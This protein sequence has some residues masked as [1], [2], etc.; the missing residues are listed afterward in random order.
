MHTSLTWAFVKRLR[1]TVKTRLLVKGLMTAEDARLAVEN[2]LDGIVVSNHGGRAEDSGRSTIDAL[3]EILEAV[4]GKVPVMVDSGFR[5][6]TDI[7]KALAM[8]AP[9]RLRSAVPI[10][11]GS[12]PSASPAS[13]ACS[14][15]CAAS[16][17]PSWCSSARRR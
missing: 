13:S 5:R 4:G 3:P 15:C 8:G 11:G 9:R 16:C 10:C 14:A 7:A 12:A 17:A 1:D 6:G 2:G